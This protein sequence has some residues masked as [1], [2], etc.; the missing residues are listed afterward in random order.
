MTAPHIEGGIRLGAGS[1][2]AKNHDADAAGNASSE[3]AVTR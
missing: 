2:A 1:S 3:Y